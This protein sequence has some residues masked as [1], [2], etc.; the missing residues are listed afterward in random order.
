MKEL[1][2]KYYEL[3][4]AIVIFISV[5]LT[6]MQFHQIVVLMLEFIVIL[7]IVRMIN[8]YIRHRNLRLRFVIDV[9][10]VFLLRD[11]VIIVTDKSL[12]TKNDEVLFLLF[13]VFV[14]FIFR[15]F[16]IKYSPYKKMKIKKVKT[17]DKDL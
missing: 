10:I 16:T 9:F 5:L 11:T 3:P 8:E 12:G 4:I 15:I 7:E 1:L 2:K 6:Q 17:E 14:L 13:I